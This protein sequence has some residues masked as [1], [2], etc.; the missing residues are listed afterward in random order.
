LRD[1]STETSYALTEVRTV[2]SRAETARLNLDGPTEYA[3]QPDGRRDYGTR[4][5][6]ED[7]ALMRAALDQVVELLEPWRRTGRSRR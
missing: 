2:L 1:R 4:T 3:L 7:A 5:D 6:D